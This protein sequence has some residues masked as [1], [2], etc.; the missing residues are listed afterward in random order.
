MENHTLRSMLCT[1][2][3]KKTLNKVTQSDFRYKQKKH[4]YGTYE[5]VEF[6]R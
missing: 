3:E 2:E 4:F 6:Y 1:E 5:N